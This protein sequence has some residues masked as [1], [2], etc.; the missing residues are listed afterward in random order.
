MQHFAKSFQSI[1]L[2]DIIPAL[3]NNSN[4]ITKLCLYG[5]H[6]SSNLPFLFGGLSGD[7]LEVLRFSSYYIEDFIQLQH[8][9][10]LNLQTLKFSY[11]CPKHEHLMKFLENNGKNLKLFH[12]TN[13][14]KA[15]RLSIANLCPNLRSLFIVFNDD[16]LNILKTIFNNCK[17]LESIKIW[18]SSTIYDGKNYLVEEEVFETV[19]NYSPNNF[20]EL[21][22]YNTSHFQIS[23]KD[24]ESFFISWKN[25]TPRKV[26]SLIILRTEKIFV[27]V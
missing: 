19:A 9:N 4:T 15:L 6:N 25:R 11:H 23:S 14:N 16:E 13:S 18:C 27:Q 17:Y 5:C 21:K 3:K 22:I 8:V 24:L 2:K 12:M 26:L 10:F 7:L 20:C 1:V